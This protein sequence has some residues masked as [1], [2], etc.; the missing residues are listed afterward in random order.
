M[1]QPID[2]TTYVDTSASASQ[3][4]ASGQQR[5]TEPAPSQIGRKRAS[6]FM[7][8]V[9]AAPPNSRRLKIA[10]ELKTMEI[11]FN[12]TVNRIKKRKH[13]IREMADKLQDDEK[14]RAQLDQS[15][16]VLKSERT[17]DE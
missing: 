6:D 7:C 17:T 1:S 10:S 8:N 3:S 15:I 5:S 16:R 11:E 9:Y 4:S 13:Q 12:R 2:V 14:K